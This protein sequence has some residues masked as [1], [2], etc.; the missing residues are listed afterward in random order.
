MSEG[1]PEIKDTKRVGGDEMPS[2]W[3]F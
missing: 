3:R 1:Y 2:R